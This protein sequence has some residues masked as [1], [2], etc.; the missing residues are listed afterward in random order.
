MRIQFKGRTATCGVVGSLF[1]SEYSPPKK[2]GIQDS[3]NG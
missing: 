2:K 1:D 3:L